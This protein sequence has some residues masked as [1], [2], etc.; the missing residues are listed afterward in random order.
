M[1]EHPCAA[2][3]DHSASAAA[4]TSVSSFTGTPRAFSKLSR[5][6]QL[7]HAVFGVARAITPDT[8]SR[9]PKQATPS[10]SMV[11]EPPWAARNHSVATLIV[12][13]GSVVGMAVATQP[14]SEPSPI[15]RTHLVPPSSMPAYGDTCQSL[16]SN[17]HHGADANDAFITPPRARAAS[18]STG[19]SERH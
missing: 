12:L 14:S 3:H 6:G 15:A 1:S 11:L 10:E 18:G 8:G 4:L 7:A 19:P 9:G 17:G 5:T 16:L 13:P 2:P